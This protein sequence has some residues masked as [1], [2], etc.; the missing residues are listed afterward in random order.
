VATVN[1]TPMKE[2]FKTFAVTVVAGIVVY[3]IVNKVPAV[4]KLVS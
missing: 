1:H 4:K 2:L 3:A